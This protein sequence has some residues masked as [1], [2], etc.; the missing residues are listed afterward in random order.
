MRGFFSRMNMAFTRFMAGR[1]GVDELS[2]VLLTAGFIICIISLIR[3][4]FFLAI[5][6][7]LLIGMS[8]FRSFSKNIAKRQ[9]EL[10]KFWA[11]KKKLKD[12]TE[13]A[14]KRYNDKTHRYFRCRLCKTVLRVPKGKGKIRITCPKCK[15]QITKKT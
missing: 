2:T 7:F 14:K 8:Y 1:Y 13:F 11:F 9:S 5:P 15:S 12:K 3:P 4:L 10:A 6:A